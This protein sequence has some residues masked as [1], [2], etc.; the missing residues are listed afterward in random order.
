MASN[1]DYEYVLDAE[2]QAIQDEITER[3]RNMPPYVPPPVPQPALP[4]PIPIM[5][6]PF[7]REEGTFFEPIKDGDLL[8]DFRGGIG[9]DKFESSFK[10]Y[11]LKI[12]VDKM[13]FHPVC[14]GPIVDKT[15]Y[16]AKILPKPEPT[17]AG[18]R[19][20]KTKRRGRKTKA[21]KPK[22]RKRIVRK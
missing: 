21:K 11:Y 13:V 22:S 6:L 20:R 8:V 19:R 4:P 17:D 16:R 14:R 18:R 7:G 9:C 10:R 5:E 3:A 15:L 12:N 1:W 2:A